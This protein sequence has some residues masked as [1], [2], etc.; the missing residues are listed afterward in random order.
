MSDSG[1]LTFTGTGN[2]IT[3]D[4]SN[5]TASSRVM[6]QTSSTDS[7]SVLGVLPNGSSG[8]AR[9]QFYNSSSP[10]SG[11]NSI[12]DIGV[13]GTT[14][15]RLQS[16]YE[17]SGTPLPMTFYTGGSERLR[18][19]TSGNCGIGTSSPAYRLDVNAASANFRIRDAS[20]GNDFVIKTIAGPVSIA[21]SVSNTA[22]AFMTNDTERMRI[23]SAG[24]VGIGINNPAAALS[25]LNNI[26]IPVVSTGGAS[27][28]LGIG[29]SGNGFA[30]ID[31]IGDATYTDFGFRAIR[32][33]G[34]ANTSSS[35]IHRG[36]GDFSISATEAAPIIFST[37]SAERMRISSSGGV[38]IGVVAPVAPLDIISGTARMFFSN[39]SSTAFFTAV[40]TTNTAYAPLAINGSEMIFKTGD[41]ERGRFTA[42]GVLNLENSVT[43]GPY[44]RGASIAVA[45]QGTVNIT[46]SE[47]GGCV[48]CVYNTGTG[49]GG[50]FWV[51]YSSVVVKIAGD[52]DVTDTGSIFAVYKNS[53][54]HLCTLKNKT[55]GLANFAIAVYSAKAQQ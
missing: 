40:N 23:T 53:G 44:L 6:F 42:A 35:L 43:K 47:A 33:D 51:N 32:G 31:L 48:V 4:F 28:E 49:D 14:D 27:L 54:E 20:A 26:A 7:G 45:S 34:G 16:T 9:I 22:I 25:V 3:G 5:A 24:N 2:R 55:G 30:F 11:T 17:I 52:G 41:A 46:V 50:V 19:D 36:T 12:F 39:Q 10:G 15:V 29:R 38:G 13:L 21:G 18:I 37:T 8:N 1:N